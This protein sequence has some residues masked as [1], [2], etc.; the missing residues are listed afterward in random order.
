ML[1]PLALAVE[2][3]PP[4]LTAANVAGYGYL[5]LFGTALAYALWFRGL[6]RLPASSVAFLGLV[7]PIVATLAG[8]VLLGQTLTPWQL[9]GLALVLTGVLLGQR[10]PRPAR[11]RLPA[12]PAPQGAPVNPAPPAREQAPTPG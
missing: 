3:P 6:E 12:P 7:N 5:G 9:A 4:A 8:L 1:A 2:G 10:P 11:T